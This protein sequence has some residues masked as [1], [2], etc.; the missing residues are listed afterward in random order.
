ME[1][2]FF[3]VLHLAGIQCIKST[4]A[5]NVIIQYRKVIVYLVRNTNRSDDDAMKCGDEGA[6]DGSSLGTNVELL[7]ET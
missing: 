1:H 2:V 6:C 7:L 3:L 4:E 5:I